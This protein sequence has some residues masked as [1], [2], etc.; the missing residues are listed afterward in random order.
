MSMFDNYPQS[1]D[2][3]PNNRPHC[4]KHKGLDIMTGETAEH[5]FEI[6][7]NVEEDCLSVEV[8]YKQGLKPVIIK[9][10]SQIDI[11]ITEHNTSVITCVLTPSET[12]LFSNSL[13]NTRVQLK[14]YM[15]NKTVSY[16]DIYK[17]KI[18]N[19]LDANKEGPIPPTP[20]PGIIG[21]IGYTED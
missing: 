2:Y 10:E 1:S 13:L 3:I 20:G 5:I 9:D 16:S 14:F 8:I 11:V 4:C 15:T 12:L 18:V 17:V 7:F 19:S 6:P 21:G